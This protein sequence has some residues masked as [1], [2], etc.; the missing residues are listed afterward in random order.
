[1]TYSPRHARLPKGHGVSDRHPQVV[2]YVSRAPR[3]L[4][5]WK[6]RQ[7]PPELRPQTHA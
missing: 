4:W 1:M 3:T 7:I 5:P 2:D 6:L